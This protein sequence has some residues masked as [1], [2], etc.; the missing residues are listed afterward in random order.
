MNATVEQAGA[1]I[2]QGRYDEAYD[3]LLD[4]RIPRSVGFGLNMKLMMVDPKTVKLETEQDLQNFVRRV[5]GANKAN[6]SGIQFGIPTMDITHPGLK[7]EQAMGALEEWVHMQQ[8][9]HGDPKDSVPMSPMIK[10]WQKTTG[11][12]PFWSEA[13]IMAR[14]IELGI[15]P[16]NPQEW[17]SRYDERGAFLDW[18][19]R[20]YKKEPW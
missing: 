13:D 4:E 10:E 11:V 6:S 14:F 20:T 1:L 2:A 3:L 12:N 19:R 5:F 16:R 18:Y 7:L 8:H 17:I 15:K 9:V